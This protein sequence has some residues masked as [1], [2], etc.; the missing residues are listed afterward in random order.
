MK[1]KYKRKKKT[2]TELATGKAEVY[3]SINKAK[4]ASRKIQ[5]DECGFLGCGAVVVIP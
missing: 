5:L 2:I 3:K 4:K 1:T